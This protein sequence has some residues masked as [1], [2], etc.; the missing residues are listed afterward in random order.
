MNSCVSWIHVS[1]YTLIHMYIQETQGIILELHFS[2]SV[3]SKT[4]QKA[5][6]W[7][8]SVVS[9]CEHRTL[10]PG[11]KCKEQVRYQPFWVN[12][13]I[14][15]CWFYTFQITE[16]EANLFDLATEP[17]W[18]AS[19]WHL[20]QMDTEHKGTFWGLYGNFVQNKKLY[21]FSHHVALISW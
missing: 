17:C 21:H 7:S 2:A 9:T 16:S 20:F 6:D 8:H 10:A 11:R 14:Q 18:N 12:Q 5:S 4:Q 1:I 19:F 13:P 3:W 15:Q